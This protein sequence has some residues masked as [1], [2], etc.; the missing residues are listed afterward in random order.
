[1]KEDKGTIA[2][3]ITNYGEKQVMPT[4]DYLVKEVNSVFQNGVELFK[5]RGEQITDF[6][7]DP[8]SKDMVTLGMMNSG[9]REFSV[10]HTILYRQRR[11]TGLELTDEEVGSWNECLHRYD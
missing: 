2:G 8:L 1:M 11:S 10:L 4:R 6:C 7:F 3:L 5:Q 9:V